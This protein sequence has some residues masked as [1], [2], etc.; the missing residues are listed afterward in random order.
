MYEGTRFGRM[1]FLV[2]DGILVLDEHANIKVM[3][4]ARDEEAVPLFETKRK[5]SNHMVIRFLQLKDMA[6]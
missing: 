1:E 3:R 5:V 6:A 2:S 4:I